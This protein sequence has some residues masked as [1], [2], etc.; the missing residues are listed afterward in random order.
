MKKIYALAI[1]V[2]T[3]ASLSAQVN[4]TL[5]VDI[6]DYLGAGNTLGAN[7]MRVGGNFGDFGVTTGGN[8]M[9]SWSP[10][11]EF[12]AMTDEGNN[13]WSIVIEIPATSAA[14]DTMYYKFVNNDWGTNEGTDTNAIASDGCGVD[15]GGGNINRVLVVPAEG[16]TLEFC[17][18]R[19]AK[20]DGTDGVTA[21]TEVEVADFSVMPNPAT[22]ETRFTFTTNATEQVSLKLYSLLGAEV[23]TVVNGTLAAGT[24]TETVNLETLS[25][26][27]YMYV[28]RSGN[29]VTQGK[30]VKQ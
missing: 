26:G 15:D 22:S 13:I 24:Y 16:Q 5:K 1:G 20:C 8:A 4:V 28:L 18:D 19:C 17:Y 3:A 27:V 7:G 10:S 12:S 25:N 2:M 14:G 30:I 9:A 29:S 11:N 21:V 23:A 6:T